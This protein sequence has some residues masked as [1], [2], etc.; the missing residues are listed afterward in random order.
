VSHA[1]GRAFLDV[2]TACPA[3]DEVRER[4]EVRVWT[5]HGHIGQALVV[6]EAAKSQVRNDLD[7]TESAARAV[8]PKSAYS[9]PRHYG[10]CP[11]GW[12]HWNRKSPLGVALVD[13]A[14]HRIQTVSPKRVATA[15]TCWLARYLVNKLKQAGKLEGLAVA[16]AA[17]RIL[18]FLGHGRRLYP[19]GHPHQLHRSVIGPRRAAMHRNL[20]SARETAEA[21]VQVMSS[22]SAPKE[23]GL[24]S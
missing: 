19:G 15:H 4:I 22:E 5:P 11:K 14:D 20:L 8:V 10:Q 3:P 1:L 7:I 16:H 12:S 21:K 13:Q 24:R 9:G 6:L 17:H 2:P 18:K 23:T